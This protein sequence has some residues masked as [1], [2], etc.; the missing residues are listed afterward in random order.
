M[1]E[2]KIHCTNDYIQHDQN[3]VS[4]IH[5][6][7]AWLSLHLN[8]VDLSLT[9]PWEKLKDT[10]WLVGEWGSRQAA[11]IHPLWALLGKQL[12]ITQCCPVRQTFP[13]PYAGHS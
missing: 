2:H 11:N 7:V 1:D 3:N 4:N 5:I 10:I 9:V 8:M 12:H 6:F 13:Q